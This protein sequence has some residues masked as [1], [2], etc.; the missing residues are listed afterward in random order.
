MRKFLSVFIFFCLIIPYVHA[1]E[2]ILVGVKHT[3]PF[4]NVESNL[5]V[6]GFSI[7]LIESIAKRLEPPRKLKY[8]IDPDMPEH[9]KSVETHKVDL[10]IAATTITAER[11]KLIDFS[12]PFYQADIAI[13]TKKEDRYRINFMEFLNSKELIMT[14][15]FILIYIVIIAHLIWLSERGAKD[16][17]FDSKYMKGVGQGLWWTV[18][19]ISTVGY[20]DVQLKKPFGRA[21]GIF[22]IFSG[23]MIFG[24]AIATLTSLLTVEQLRPSINGPEDLPGHRIAVLNKTFTA[25]ITA[26]MGVNQKIVRSLHEGLVDLDHGRVDALVHDRPLLKYLI[27]DL[28]D[29][30]Y[31]LVDKGFAPST[32]G[33]TFPQDS[34]LEEMINY[35][36]LKIMEGDDSFYN[37]IHR[38][39]FGN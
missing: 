7:D 11:E 1:N 38:K 35:S 27:K 14:V 12:Q 17:H 25:E 30:R 24:V 39:W 13:L 6:N 37:Q 36:L 20:G 16:G 10:G 4:V 19:T 34:P 23:I 21:L 18:V 15:I 8:H 9:L 32:Y 22:V 31:Y 29:N 5:S 28:D 33:I 3:P 26:K 2:E